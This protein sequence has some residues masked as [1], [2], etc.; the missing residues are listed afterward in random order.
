MPPPRND[1]ETRPLLS[2]DGNGDVE[3]TIGIDQTSSHHGSETFERREV[4]FLNDDHDAAAANYDHDHDVDE[5]YEDPRAWPPRRKMLNVTIIALMAILS[6]LASSMFTPGIA[7]IAADLRTDE[8]SVIAT[9]TGFVVTLG[10]GPL[11]WAPL[12]EDF[13]R[14]TLYVAC[15][16]VFT[17]LQV[18]SALS[19]GIRTLIAVRTVSGFFGSEFLFFVSS[20]SRVLF[21]VVCG[22]FG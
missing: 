16:A 22:I 13:G 5:D 2:P 17:V 15:F 19:P 18:V 11:V 8:Q 1:E 14:R 6:P 21:E 12:S 4:R 3:N 20:F 9:T 10:L 7:Q